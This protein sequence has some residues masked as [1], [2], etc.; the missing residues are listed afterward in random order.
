M[1]VFDPL[2]SLAL[3]L[4]GPSVEVP[5]AT[6]EFEMTAQQQT[7]LEEARA[8]A[9]QQGLLKAERERSM[10]RCTDPQPAPFH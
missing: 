3:A 6:E 8:E 5:G 2:Q 1:K 7:A 9:V 10:V 4:A